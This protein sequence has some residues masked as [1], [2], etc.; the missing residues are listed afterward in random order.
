MFSL[1]FSTEETD[2]SRNPK[3]Q[4]FMLLWKEIRHEQKV[5]ERIVHILEPG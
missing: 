4:H 3:R 1:R 2:R 5:I